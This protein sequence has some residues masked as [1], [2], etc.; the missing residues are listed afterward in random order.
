SG[1][2]SS[3][4][5]STAS[6]TPAGTYTVT[7]T[8]TG[9][10]ATRTATYTLTVT[11]AGGCTNAGQKLANPGFESGS[12]SWT[13]TSGVIGQWGS[14]GNAPRTG[15]WNAWMNGYGSSHTDTVSQTVAVPAGCTTYTLSLWL[16]VKTSETTTTTAYDTFR[17]QVVSGGVTTTLGTYS[18]LN[19][20]SAYVQRSF[21]LSAY[22]GK[23]VTVTFRGVEDAY[24][25]TTF[26]V[27]DTALT[28]S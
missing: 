25:Q 9:A 19:K 16:H 11:V 17:V 20:S 21:N 1:G 12:T 26:L 6:T 23:T 4:T 10:S 7:V 15:T 22:A 24:L 18:N 5:I 14:Y 8:G 3:M 13:A 28:V 2:S 27:D